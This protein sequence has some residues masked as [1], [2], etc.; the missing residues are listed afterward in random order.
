VETFKVSGSGPVR[1]FGDLQASIMEVLWTRGEGTVQDVCDCLGPDEHN[2]KTVMTVLNRLAGKSVLARQRE[3]KAFVYRPAKSREAFMADMS[4]GVMAGLVRD[5]G[6]AAVAQFVDVLDEVAPE[7]L[8]QLEA[9]LKARSQVG[10]VA[11]DA[12][13]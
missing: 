4:K 2:Y 12:R 8:A 13:G 3:G 9:L 5:L 1:V 6:G 11:R 10:G 7:Q